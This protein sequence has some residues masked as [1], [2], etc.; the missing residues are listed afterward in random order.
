MAK[1]K[2][3]HP[4]RHSEN[5]KLDEETLNQTI[6]KKAYEIYE[7]RGGGHGQDLDDW[8]EAENIVKGK[9]KKRLVKKASK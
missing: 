8:I 3:I 2:G 4:R 1:A 5:A 6:R 7:K 9:R